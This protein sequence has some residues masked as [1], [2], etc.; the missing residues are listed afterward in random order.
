MA[1]KSTT[2][3]KVFERR[4]ATA[5]REQWPNA[6]VRRASQADRA[7]NPDVLVEAGPPVLSRLWLELQDARAP[8]PTDKLKQAE[9]D[10]ARWQSTRMPSVPRLPVVVWHKLAERTIWVTTRMWVLD[11]LRRVDILRDRDEWAG[12]DRECRLEWDDFVWLV[13]LYARGEQTQEAA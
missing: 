6:V 13:Q 5:L 3:G 7:D 10:V 1:K 12:G 9:R 11:V 8:T 2:K 4:I